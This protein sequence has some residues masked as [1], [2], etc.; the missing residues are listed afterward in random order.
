MIERLVSQKYLHCGFGCEFSA[1]AWLMARVLGKIEDISYD[2]RLLNMAL[3][4][5]TLLHASK[6]FFC[7][8]N[9][10]FDPKRKCTLL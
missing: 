10:P 5:E 9:G 8:Q 7:A 6:V 2:S 4:E 3:T 1:S